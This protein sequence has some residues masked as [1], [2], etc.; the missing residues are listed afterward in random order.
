MFTIYWPVSPHLCKHRSYTIYTIRKTGHVSKK[1]VKSM[2][3]RHFYFATNIIYIHNK[4]NGIC[5]WKARKINNY[6]R[7]YFLAFL[8]NT[9]KYYIHSKKNGMC[10]QKARRFNK[11]QTSIKLDIIPHYIHNKKNGITPQ[12]PRF[13]W[14]IGLHA[15]PKN[16][17][18]DILQSAGSNR[19]FCGAKRTRCGAS[20]LNL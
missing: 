10:P 2:I 7:F 5:A 3:F 16:Q 8:I 11:N 14:I 4:K 20:G 13:Y 15:F 18:T 19:R 6:R 9:W 1:P 12:S 17:H